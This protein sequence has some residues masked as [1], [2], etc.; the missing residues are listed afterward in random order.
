MNGESLQVAYKIYDH[1][2]EWKGNFDYARTC[3]KQALEQIDYPEDLEIISGEIINMV[4]KSIQVITPEAI[5]N[6]M[7]VS[8]LKPGM[9]F[10]Q[11]NTSE[12]IMS[13]KLVIQ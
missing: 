3:I 12:G 13:R 10:I 4:G 8:S 9:Y 1:K 5:E 6:V 11:L 7:D 2:F